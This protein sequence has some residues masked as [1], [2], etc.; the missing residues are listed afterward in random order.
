MV[1][2]SRESGFSKEGEG[3]IWATQGRFV[4]L[5]VLCLLAFEDAALK[6]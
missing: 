5:P 4:I 6:S 2:F 3:R 1:L